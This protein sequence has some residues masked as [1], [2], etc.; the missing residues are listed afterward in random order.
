MAVGCIG[1]ENE[2]VLYIKHTDLPQ[3]TDRNF[4]EHT[5]CTMYWIK[6]SSVCVCVLFIVIIINVLLFILS[7]EKQDY[8]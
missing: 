5:K 2:Q 3:V 8:A 1:K 7:I 4:I 6:N